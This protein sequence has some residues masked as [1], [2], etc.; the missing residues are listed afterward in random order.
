MNRIAL[1]GNWTLKRLADGSSRP[2]AIPGDI[3][4]ALIALGEAP[5]PYYDRNELSLQWIGREDWLL[6]RDIEL[7]PEFLSRERIFLEIQVLDTI[8]EIRVNGALLGSSTNMFKSFSANT[9]PLLHTGRNRLS[10]LIRSPE[11]AAAEAAKSL[12]YPIPYSIYPVVS[13]HRNLIRKVQCMSGWDWGP[14]L[15]TGGIYD[16][17]SLVAL[18]GPRIEYVT[19][20]IRRECGDRGGSLWRLSVTAWLDCPSAISLEVEASIGGIASEEA[21]GAPDGAK[22]GQ[23]KG[24]FELAAG[25]SKAALELTVTDVKEWWPAGYGDQPLYELEVRCPATGQA[26][27]KRIGFRELAVVA[28]EDA[29][30][31]S[32]TFRVNGRDIFCKGANW[33]PADALPSRWTRERLDDLISSAAQANMNCLRVWGGGRYESDDFYDLCDEKGILVWQDCMF[34]CALYP[35]EPAFLAEVEAELRHQVKRLK[36]HPSLALWCGNN[37]NLG[38]LGW[39]AESKGN[40]MRYIVDY[41][42]LYEGTLGRVVRELDPDRT[43]WP[44]S[45]SGGPSDFADNWHGDGRGDMHFWSVWHEGKSFSEYLTVKPRFCSEFGFQS[46]PSYAT[47][48]SFAPEGERNVTSPTMEHHQRHNRGNAIIMETMARYFR[49]PAGTRETLYLSQVQ[50]ARAIQTAVE[51]W[52]SLRPLCMGTLYWQLNDVWP[53]SSWS[54]LDY[55]GSWKTLHYE[56]RRFFEPLHLALIVKDGRFRAVAINDGAETYKGGLRMRLRRPDGSVVAEY[57]TEA[58]VTPE[59]AVELHSLELSSLPCRPEEAFMEASLELHGPSE[60]KVE[61]GALAFLAE[62]KRYSLLDPRIE[63]TVVAGTEGTDLVLRAEK[64]AFYV[65][66]EAGGIEGRF[67]DSGFHLMPGEERCLRFLPARG[68]SSPSAEAIK[69]ALRIM[70][71]R[72]SYE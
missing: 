20:R 23:A 54:S 19:T 67:E 27:R 59:S 40:P 47:L 66:P 69:A 61:R 17:I 3:L 11:L 43:W 51:Y 16:G 52:R 58:R 71:L 15:M 46:F 33:I 22:L 56:S 57:A 4:S 6:E 2:M 41:D 37:E 38:A 32:M 70:H 30:G 68:Q 64:P 36:D 29:A 14:C 26:L 1:Q 18:D 42:R 7:S 49:M 31:R 28:E 12:P 24:R 9:K 10:V 50:Q 62:P 21:E 48:A 39:Y 55:D 35:S 72:A 44:S 8:A 13:M 5:D 53:V 34:A 25:S 65:V 60:S 45:P 63:A